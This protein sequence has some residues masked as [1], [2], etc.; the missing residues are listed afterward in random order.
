M[1]TTQDI[2]GWIARDRN[3]DLNFFEE[4]PSRDNKGGY[5]MNKRGTMYYSLPSSFFPEL[6]WTD[7]PVYVKL[8]IEKL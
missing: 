3:D 7:D 1:A 8:T 5:W 6:E 4:F 2:T